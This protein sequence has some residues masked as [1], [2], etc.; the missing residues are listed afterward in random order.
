MTLLPQAGALGLAT[1]PAPEPAARPPRQAAHPSARPRLLA[2]QVVAVGV[3][4]EV[5]Q[6]VELWDQLLDVWAGQGRRHAGGCQDNPSQVWSGR[7]GGRGRQRSTSARRRSRSGGKTARP[8]S[9]RRRR[10]PRQSGAAPARQPAH[11][12]CCPGSCARWRPRCGTAGRRGQ[13]ARP[14]QRG[15]RGGTARRASACEAGGI[16]RQQP[17]AVVKAPALQPHHGGVAGEARQSG[18]HAREGQ[19]GLGLCGRGR[20]SR[21]RARAHAWRQ[22]QALGQ[23]PKLARACSWRASLVK[24]SRRSR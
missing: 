19:V 4:Q 11:P 23:A 16:G 14:A 3:E 8:A 5:G 1:S 24:P 2:P 13:S 7:G 6:A 10:S 20:C 17:V 22:G 12:P 15:S 18:E 21:G 9:G